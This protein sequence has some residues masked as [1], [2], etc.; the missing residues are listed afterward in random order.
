MDSQPLLRCSQQLLDPEEPALA[1]GEGQGC[2]RRFQLNI[3]GD[4]MHLSGDE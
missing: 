1:E 2:E 3:N 4:A